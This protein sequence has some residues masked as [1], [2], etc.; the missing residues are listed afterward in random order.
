MNTCKLYF[1]ALI[2]LVLSNFGPFLSLIRAEIEP[3]HAVVREI[4]G[5]AYYSEKEGIWIP[6]KVKTRLQA[7]MMVKTSPE[8][9][10]VFEWEKSGGI[11]RANSDTIL[12]LAKLSV[13]DTPLEI[14][15]ETDIDLIQGSLAGTE[16]K[17]LGASQLKINSSNGSARLEGSQYEI[18]A[19]GVVSVSRGSAIFNSAKSQGRIAAGQT[20]NPNTGTTAFYRAPASTSSS[21]MASAS[22]SKQSSPSERSVSPHG[23]NG[24]G[25]GVDP[26]PPGNPPVNDGPGTGPGNPGNGKK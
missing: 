18:D 10:A 1:V 23:N 24:V 15:A 20:F 21:Q 3:D 4:K 25:N 12:R 17:S 8:S 2:G 7:G 6:L 9:S 11:L 5:V 22:A 26:A 19:D 16:K 13:F 14:I